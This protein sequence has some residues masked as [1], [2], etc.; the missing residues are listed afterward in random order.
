[1]PGF[2]HGEAFSRTVGWVTAEELESL[3]GKRVAIAGVGG[4]GGAHVLTFARLGVGALTLA[5]PDAFELHNFNRQVGATMAS[6]G[7]SSASPNTA[8]CAPSSAPSDAG[9]GSA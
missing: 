4:A 7:S 3:R 9:T 2:D 6:L 8:A 5:D 1:M